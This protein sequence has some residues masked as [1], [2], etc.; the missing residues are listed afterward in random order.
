ML[1]RSEQ[2][3][4]L[5]ISVAAIVIPVGFHVAIDAREN[6]DVSITDQAVLNMSR[7]IAVILLFVY[8]S[9]LCFQLWTHAC[10]CSTISGVCAEVDS[11]TTHRS[12]RT[13]RSRA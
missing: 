7:G 8:A 11:A 4:L 1:I 5:G 3:N 10:E 13:T 9:Y 2:I 12:L 6:T